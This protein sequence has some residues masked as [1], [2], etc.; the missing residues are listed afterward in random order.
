MTRVARVR[1][2][3]HQITHY[4]EK[5]PEMQKSRRLIRTLFLTMLL[6]F[7]AGTSLM[8]PGNATTTA[9]VQQTTSRERVDW[10]IPANQCPRLPAG[11][12]V[13][14]SGHRVQHVVTNKRPNGTT[15]IT[16]I[17]TVKGHA[18]DSRGHH[19]TFFYHNESVEN[20]PAAQDQPIAVHMVDV[21]VLQG[22]NHHHKHRGFTV[23]FNW[24]WSYT[25]PAEIWPPAD[26]LHK[27]AT[28][29]DPYLCDPI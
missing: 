23:F 10:K 4:L 6:V 29:G 27:I 15:R 25:P 2:I 28:Y 19:Y 12:S 7:A 14:G 21:F 11:V 18:K 13:T 24:T 17:D 1:A 3:P 26:N 9:Q 16:V 22:R 8:S 20:V 5:E